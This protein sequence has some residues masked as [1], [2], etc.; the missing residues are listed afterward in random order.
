MVVET[1]IFPDGRLISEVVERE[2]GENCE[3]IRML[4]T[5]YVVSEEKTGPDC[6]EVHETQ[7]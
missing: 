4:N 7:N 5:G 1:T 2:T 3:H 6:D